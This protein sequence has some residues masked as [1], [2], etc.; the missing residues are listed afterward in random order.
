MLILLLSAFQNCVPYCRIL[1]TTISLV[2]AHRMLQQKGQQRPG[3]D[4]HFQECK[5]VQE[6]HEND[7]WTV[8]KPEGKGNM[9]ALW[10]FLEFDMIFSWVIL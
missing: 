6:H 4:P 7:N 10:E 5:L 1:V 9:C 3:T 2:K 8:Q